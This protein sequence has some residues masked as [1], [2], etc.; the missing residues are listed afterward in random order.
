MIKQVP[1]TTADELKGAFGEDPRVHNVA[2]DF[3]GEIRRRCG[4]FYDRRDACQ[5]R[6][7]QFLQH[8]PHWEVEGV[9][10][11]CCTFERDVDVLTEKPAC[12]GQHFDAAIHV[13]SAVGQL[14]RAF[15]AVDKQRA[16]TAVD[17]D[18]GVVLGCACGVG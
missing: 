8:S 2:N 3:L 14:A 13:H 4:R 16:D 1:H 9:D 18:P 15:A 5:E 11:Y 10:V 7:G 12:F 17:I 6:G